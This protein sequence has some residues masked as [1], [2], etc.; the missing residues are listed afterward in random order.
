MSHPSKGHVRLRALRAGLIGLFSVLL[1]LIAPS[2]SAQN[3][4]Q[5]FDAIPCQFDAGVTGT[6]TVPA[7]TSGLAWTG[8][9]CMNGANNPTPGQ[10][11]A[12]GATSAPHVGWAFGS[13][14]LMRNGG[15]V[16]SLTSAQMTAAWQDIT[17]TATGYLGAT[18]V[19]TQTIPLSRTAPT[20][21][22]FSGMVNVDRVVFS[23]SAVSQMVFDDVR[24]FLP[25]P[26]AITS[27]AVPSAGGTVNCTPN[28]VQAGANA[29]CTATANPGYTLN[30]FTGCTSVS[31]NTC[32]LNAVMA[33]L[34]V[35]ANFSPIQYPVTS[36]AAP[37]AGGSVVCTPNPVNHGGNASCTAMVSAGYTLSGFT[38]CS[39]VS[40][41]ICTLNNVQAPISVTANFSQ[42]TYAI[43]ATPSPVAGGSLA[44]TPNP[45]LHGGNAT[46]T[47]TVNAGYTLSGF[48]GCSSVSGNLCT[49]NNV[50][51]P[52]SVTAN[53]AQITHAVT[54]TPNPVAG[55]NVACTPNPVAQG[56][57]A[58]CTATANA[59][60]TLSGFTGCSSVS[61][62]L[63]TLS[64]VQAPADV[65]VNFSQIMHA[66]T[67]TS[68]PAAGGSIACTLNSVAQG[69]DAACTATANADYTLSGFTGCSSVNGNVCTLSS[70]Q[71]PIDVTANFTQIMHTITATPSPLAGGTVECTPNPVAQGSDATC[72]A[73]VNAGYTL[74][75]FTGCTSVSGNLC[76]LTDVQ[77]DAPTVTARFAVAGAIA[78]PSLSEGMLAL[79]CMLAGAFGVSRLRRARSAM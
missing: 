44:C 73:T 6:T 29:S 37:L 40:G 8:F 27:V 33:P 56:S 1:G 14:T 17:A 77:E 74:S 79:L 18:P 75:G 54:A 24:Y 20:L 34:T 43:T 26:H 3:M 28:P 70:V 64:N 32:S 11:Y 52:T 22:T 60:Y 25:S 38:G 47:A 50:Q 21:V 39:S 41:N 4:L 63:C 59:G 69:S 31:G 55:G 53:F 15:G 7:G 62:N 61:G 19:A 30:G 51:A 48:T 36:T 45:V 78:V 35:T 67:A 71:A 68:S 13:G 16:F 65:M 57:D 58:T 9:F 42:I 2:V 10:S 46:C 72:T 49:L 76:T 66:I 23:G 12:V 5:N